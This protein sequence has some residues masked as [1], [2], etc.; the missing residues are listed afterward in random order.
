VGLATKARDPEDREEKAWPL[1]MLKV[2]SEFLSSTWCALLKTRVSKPLSKL[3][4]P[5]QKQRIPTQK[6]KA[7]FVPMDCAVKQQKIWGK[8]WW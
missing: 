7:Q 2:G 8:K 4:N 3:P 5:N 1:G 6:Y